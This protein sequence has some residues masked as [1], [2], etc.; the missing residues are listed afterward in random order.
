MPPYNR[1]RARNPR[2][3][4]NGLLQAL[5]TQPERASYTWSIF[6]TLHIEHCDVQSV[7]VWLHLILLPEFLLTSLGLLFR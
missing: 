6:R 5:E 1:L 7:T 4:K 3:A 2:D